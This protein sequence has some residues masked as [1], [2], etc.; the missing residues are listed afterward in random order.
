MALPGPGSPQHWKAL[1][2]TLAASGLLPG[3]RLPEV[4][5]DA[6]LERILQTAPADKWF[7]ILD[8]AG[9]PCEVS[10]STYSMGVFDDE[11][12]RERGW[13]VQWQHPHVGRLEQYG[14]GVDLSDTPLVLERPTP[15]V[16]QHSVELLGEA[17]YT[18]K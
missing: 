10:S 8:A 16:G 3:R 15:I 6:L 11:E 18:P 12:L 17:G 7:E 2:E 14:L 4:G 13:T 5:R 9:V 1:E